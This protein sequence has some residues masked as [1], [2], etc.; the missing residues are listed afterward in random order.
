VLAVWWDIPEAAITYTGVSPGH[1]PDLPGRTH[2]A[3]RENPMNHKVN[4]LVTCLAAA[5]ATSAMIAATSTAA[6]V[7]PVFSGT[8]TTF[9][10]DGN[11]GTFSVAGGA[12]LACSKIGSTSTGTVE[13]SRN[14]GTG[15]I[16]FEGCSEGGE[17]CASLGLA[18]STAKIEVTGTWHLV[19]RTF[20]STD[21]HY[22]LFLFN[23]V[24]FECPK[25]TVKLFLLTG[26]VDGL[27]AQ[28]VG[29][30]DVFN[31]TVKT[32]NGAGTVQEYSEFENEAG[33][34]IKTKIELSQEG[35]KA[36][37]AFE[38]STLNTLIF[39][40]TTSIEK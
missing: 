29:V 25:A 38:E 36:K 10:A 4:V 34:G 16:I 19:L 18:E 5:F 6:M 14:L 37:E 2:K 23:N 22:F 1:S 39:E 32:V 26:D 40:L 17:K 12:K 8:D 31:F 24:H 27:I 15:T 28:A 9:K 30:P 35:G 33:T 21:N 11:A 7:L 20:G 3:K 13:A